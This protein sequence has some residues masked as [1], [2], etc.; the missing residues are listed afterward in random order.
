MSEYLKTYNLSLE[1]ISPLFI[2]DGNNL[3][4]KEYI[5]L[6]DR[7]QVL[8]LDLGEMY[9]DILRKG[10][11][12]TQFFTNFLSDS[13]DGLKKWLGDNANRLEYNPKWERY[14]LEG[15]DPK[16]GGPNPAD[17]DTFIKD[18]YGDPYI[19]GTS[20]KGMLRSLLLT[21]EL[22]RNSDLVNPDLVKEINDIKKSVAAAASMDADKNPDKN[23]LKKEA[24]LLETAVLHTL[25]RQ[26]EHG[27]DL[28]RED[29]VNDVLS[30]LI[31][32]DSKP[33]DWSNMI[34]CR[35]FD[36]PL[37]E[38][39]PSKKDKKRIE[40]LRE[41]VRPGTVI[42]FSLTID[43]TV[44]PYTWEDIQKAVKVFNKQY[45]D[46]Y[47]KH[48]KVGCPA[49]NIVWLGG[50]AGFFTKTVLYSLMGREEGLKAAR[51]VFRHTLGKKN[52]EMHKHDED[53]TVSPHMLK[54]AEYKGIQYNQM[55]Q[56]C[57]LNNSEGKV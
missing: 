25:R 7:K 19:P 46:Y 40:L 11:E 17:I 48:F 47:L 4:N 55:G 44:C 24:D 53:K 8:V 38:P 27:K 54:C 45:Y 42:N 35:T 5:Y 13:S 52:Y 32:S 3:T 1:T 14:F 28:P 50:R 2:G 49:D 56:C 22:T 31:V 37:P 30:G 18:G 16:L 26:D 43:T 23:Y 36:R 9:K 33:I 20:I 57:L 12:L 41:A 39:V 10:K 21:Y 34:V 29:A 51:A 6:P 15:G